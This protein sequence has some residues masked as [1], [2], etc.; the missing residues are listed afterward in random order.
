MSKTHCRNCGEEMEDPRPGMAQGLIA[1]GACKSD[2]E[3]VRT[4]L[5]T[6]YVYCPDCERELTRLN[7]Q[8][9]DLAVIIGNRTMGYFQQFGQ[10]RRA[11]RGREEANR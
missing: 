5:L 3:A 1:T 6:D 2:P 8:A 9:R 11:A 7:K 4:A 10:E